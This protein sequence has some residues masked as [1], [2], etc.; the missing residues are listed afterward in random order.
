MDFVRVG[1]EVDEGALLEAEQRRVG[2]A[3][4]LVLTNGALP[5]LTGH[6][7]LEFAGRH[8]DAIERE[9]QIDLA[10]RAGMAARLPRHRELIA[11][12]SR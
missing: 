5:G 1:G 7:I 9:Q 11:L 6:R 8:R 12:E 3:I 4:L 10:A 2:I